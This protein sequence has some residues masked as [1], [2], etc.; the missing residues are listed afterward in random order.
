MAFPSFYLDEV[1]GTFVF[2][3]NYD[4]SFLDLKGLPEFYVNV[5]SAWSELKNEGM[6]EDCLQ[7]HEE[8]LWNN[9]NIIIGGKSI[10]YKDWHA[11][12]IE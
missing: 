7:V 8:I 12:G 5:L 1:G 2:K 10:Y 11:L 4:V 3:C 6:A 9:K